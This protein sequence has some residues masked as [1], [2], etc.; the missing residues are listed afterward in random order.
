MT[1][2]HCRADYS[3]YLSFLLWYKLPVTHIIWHSSLPSSLLRL[4]VCRTGGVIWPLASR[5]RSDLFAVGIA[6]SQKLF[7]A[8]LVLRIVVMRSQVVP[9]LWSAAYC[10]ICHTLDSSAITVLAQFIPLL[11]LSVFYR[12]WRIRYHQ[13]IFSEY[14]L[15]ITKSAVML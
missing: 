5:R 14:I 4:T 11:L 13:T 3:L 7:S 10:S 1:L 15:T 6:A 8:L 12:C 9:D 2:L